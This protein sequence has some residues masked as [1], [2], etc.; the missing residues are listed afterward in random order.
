MISYL[1]GAE[2]LADARLRLGAL[3]A[4]QGIL[5]VEGYDDVR[6]FSPHSVGKES[7]LPC[8]NKDKLLD[9]YGRLEP[10]EEARI[11]FVA[12]C[13][14]DVP[15]ERLRPASNLIITDYVDV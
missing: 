11:V 2:V 1:S 10:G 4:D 14:Y 12:D 7:L 8:G 13:D 3:P 15:A 5:I 9:A 6:L